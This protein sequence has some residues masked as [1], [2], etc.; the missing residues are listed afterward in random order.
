MGLRLFSVTVMF[1]AAAAGQTVP[2][3]E[4]QITGAPYV[5]PSQTILKVETRLVEVGVVVRDAHGHAV[6]GLTRD[7]FE[8]EESGKKRE[9]TAFSAETGPPPRP[10]N[11][12]NTPAAPAGP[13]AATAKRLPRLLALVFDDF[14]MAASELMPTRAA[15]RQFFKE[16]MAGDDRASLFFVSKGQ[17]VPFTSDAP[18]LEQALN[19]LNLR[20]RDAAMATCPYLNSYEALMIA[21]HLD[22]A[23]LMAKVQEAT[24]C[25]ICR[26][27]DSSCPGKV[28]SIARPVWDQ[29]RDTC[30][31]TLLFLDEIVKYMAALPGRRVIVLASSGFLSRTLEQEREN[32]IDR[33]L[34]AGIVI[35]ALDAKGLF[36]QDLGTTGP[37]MSLASSMLRMSMGTRPQMEA[38]DSLAILSASTGGLFFHNNNDLAL[39]FRE[40]G[41]APEASY[42]IGLTPAGP[43]DNRYHTLKVRL[44]TKGR[45]SIQARP[46]YFAEISPKSTAPAERSIDREVLLTA[47]SGEVPAAILLVDAAHEA[48]L[49]LV[50]HLDIRHLPFANHGNLR[51]LSMEI[52]AALFDEHALF[53]GGEA[54]HASFALKDET[55]RRLA[56]GLN[57]G[58]TVA[59]PAG[60]YRLRC[61]IQEEN[62]GKL[63]ALE[64]AVEI[65]PAAR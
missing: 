25:G 13:P 30:R 18:R 28:E 9:I 34:R 15:A 19:G 59:A 40:L 41:L 5:P 6:A 26:P 46:G 56:D 36:T 53:V 44:K 12:A 22:P 58:L 48:G 29:A 17:V 60:K 3:D 50:L 14:S 61:V 16:G 62:G 21:E 37:A 47:V 57:I 49:H 43:P 11:A 10:A 51:T 65:G 54:A 7:D 33:A 42:S 27:R 55:Y 2:A 52:V 1:A 45:Y 38:N 4:L 24:S 63:T 31:R 64:R 8:V 32:V 35:H 39:G 20:N 23:V